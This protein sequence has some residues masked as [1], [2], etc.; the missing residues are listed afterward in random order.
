LKQTLKIECP[1][2]SWKP[3]GGKYW[4]CDCGNVWNTFD[5]AGRCP[6]CKILWEMT[7]CPGPSYPGGCGRFSPHLKW[8]KDFIVKDIEQLEKLIKQKEEEIIN[9]Y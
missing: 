4:S 7:Q 2:C 6:T 5:T 9:L 1:V 3:D 8:Y